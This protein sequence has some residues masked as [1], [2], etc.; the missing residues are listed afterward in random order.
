MSSP[1]SEDSML[2]QRLMTTVDE[3]KLVALLNSKLYINYTTS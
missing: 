1:A 2:C 3:V